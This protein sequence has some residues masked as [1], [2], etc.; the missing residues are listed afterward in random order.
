MT[1]TSPHVSR[2][3][4]GGRGG[5]AF[6]PTGAPALS[7]Q[8]EGEPGWRQ[9]AARVELRRAGD[10][11]AVDIEGADS[12]AIGWPF[13][14]LAPYTEAEIRVAVRSADGDWSEPGVWNR[15]RTAALG[16]G[17]WSAAFI[18]SPTPTDESRGTVRFRRS[19]EVRG[20]VRSAILSAT[21]HGVLETV[22]N[23]APTSDEV[24]AP[25][26]TAYDQRLLFSSSDVTSLLRPGRNILGATVAEGWYRERFGFDGRFAVAY[27][28]PTALSAQLRIEYQDGSVDLITTDESWETSTVGPCVS[29]SIYQGEHY[30]ARLEDAAL[31]DPAASLPGAASAVIV[32]ASPERLESS[33]VPPVR[34]IERVA[35]TDVLT[36]ASGR[37]ILDFGQNLVGWL[38]L[39]LDLPV[40]TEITLRHAEVLENGELGIRPL[41][42]AAATDRYTAAGGER[43]WSPR[44]TFHGFRYAQIDGLPEEIDPTHVTAIVVH[45]DLERT[46]WLETSDP[47]LN[48]LHQNVLWGMRGNFLSIPTDCPQRDERLGWTGDIQVFGPTASYLYDVSGFLRSWLRDLA[49]QQ[50]DTGV[51]MVIPSPLP[52]PPTAAA[53]WGDAATLLPDTLFTRYGDAAVLEEQYASMRAWVE[54]LRRLAGDDHLWTG[55]FQFGDWLDPSA[56]PHNP[57]GAKTD[58]DIVATAHYFRSAGRLAEAARVLG[59]DDDV[60]EYS[61]LA[62]SVREAWVH[63]YVTGAGRVLSDAHTAYA[64]AIAFGILEGEQRQAAGNRL[65]ELVRA[66]GYRVRTGFVGTPLI[67]DA[68]TKT[69]HVDTAYRLLLE[70]GNPSWLYPISMGATTIWERWD[71][72]LPDGTINPGEMTSFN[73][74]ALGAVADWMQRT[75]GGIAPA[76]PGYRLM[77]IEPRPGGGLTSARAALETGYGRIETH[78]RIEDD[79]F[80]LALTVPS[81]TEARVILP[82]GDGEIR[83]GSG[84]H[85]WIVPLAAPRE[86]TRAFSLDSPLAH[87]ADDPD[88][89][90]A[91][92][93]FFAGIGYFIAS[94]WNTSGSWRSDAR[95]G[96]SLIMFPREQRPRLEALLVD[97]NAR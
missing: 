3:R 24:L 96:S 9:H 85:E 48:Q 22:V 69:G 40:S 65:A 56:P 94:G 20:A 53:A 83:V 77:T 29:A 75:I 34:R 60:R 21:A 23:G 5:P 62:E 35:V 39:R 36:S 64:L 71:S 76:E 30:D 12:Q 31:T 17:D 90:A 95:L 59:K 27:P 16:P 52:D 93:Q 44:F 46:G 26:W 42:H 19:V 78:W 6:L 72:M 14:P 32:D 28:G 82:G 66:F 15:V 7:W 49:L 88:A 58:A 1:H 55:T 51:P 18:A 68:L 67:C 73:H 63:E 87:F 33:P 50:T 91:L 79:R 45:T 81:G 37:P 70:R 4:L 47:M 74:Y 10:I 43:T 97:L 13:A 92:E 38:E 86:S 80:L 11:E 54:T 41:R 89:K 2:L 25:G 57:A 61:A 84:R 8:V